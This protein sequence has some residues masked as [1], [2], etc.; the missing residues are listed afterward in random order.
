MRSM[1][2]MRD[3]PIMKAGDD[4]TLRTVLATDP[5]KTVQREFRIEIPEGISNHVHQ[6]DASNFHLALPPTDRLDEAQV[7]RITGGSAFG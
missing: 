6:T 4:E 1:T 7:E 3:H 2:Q 5:K